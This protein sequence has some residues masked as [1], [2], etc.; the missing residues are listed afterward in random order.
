MALGF[1]AG[2]ILGGWRAVNDARG[3]TADAEITAIQADYP[4]RRVYDVRFVTRAG[5]TCKSTVDSGSEP[6]PRDIH[7]GGRSLVHYPASNPCD[8]LYIR[9]MP[10]TGPWPPLIPLAIAD[11]ACLAA[12]W[13]LRPP[14]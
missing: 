14:A 1:T 9:E 10:S 13:R 4:G 2:L 8:G 7:M 12:I 6:E 3:S 5:R 11:A